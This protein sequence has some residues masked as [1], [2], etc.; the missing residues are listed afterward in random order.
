MVLSGGIIVMVPAPGVQMYVLESV[1]TGDGGG[2]G[3]GMG[4]DGGD[5]ITKPAHGVQVN[6]SMSG[7][8]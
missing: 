8:G 3:G 2:G 7:I 4:G 1:V 6:V 5:D